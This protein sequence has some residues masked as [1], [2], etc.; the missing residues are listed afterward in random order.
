MANLYSGTKTFTGYKTLAELT[1]LTFEANK[2]YTIQIKSNSSYFVREG[3]EGVGF[4]D[5]YHKPFS[6]Q[7]DGENNLYIGNVYAPSLVINV[8]G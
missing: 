5:I 2:T 3:T 6:W 1:E 8:A 4:E 7:Y